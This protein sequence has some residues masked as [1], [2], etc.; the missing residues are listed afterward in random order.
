MRVPAEFSHTSREWGV[1]R[2]MLE[3]EKELLVGKLC[4]LECSQ[5]VT[6]QLRGRIA[7]IRDF[8]A[9]VDAA[10]KERLRT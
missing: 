9:S 5:T 7:F 1:I 3:E 2:D 6:E 8:L 4:S 10:A